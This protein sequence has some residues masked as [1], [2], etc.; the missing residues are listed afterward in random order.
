MNQSTHFG[1][2]AVSSACPKVFTHWA[3]SALATRT[4]RHSKTRVNLHNEPKRAAEELRTSDPVGTRS[5]RVPLLFVATTSLKPKRRSAHPTAI[6]SQSH[7]VGTR[8]IRVPLL[9]VATTS[10][11][12][13]HC[14]AHTT[15]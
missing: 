1:S 4:F 9:F 15:A 10:L 12:P 7:P 11:K 13:E 2:P 6:I 5:I 8:S 14:S 3:Q